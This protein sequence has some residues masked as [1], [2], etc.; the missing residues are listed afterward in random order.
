MAQSS[1]KK[2][3]KGKKGGAKKKTY[4][5]DPSHQSEIPMKRPKISREQQLLG[6]AS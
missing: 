3:K 5:N 4:I 2:K 1:G 6:G